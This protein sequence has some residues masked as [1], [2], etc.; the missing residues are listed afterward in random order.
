[1]AKSLTVFASEK[2]K[3]RKREQSEKVDF[4]EWDKTLRE[5]TANELLVKHFKVPSPNQE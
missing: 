3:R 4:P 5:L 2:T 1:M